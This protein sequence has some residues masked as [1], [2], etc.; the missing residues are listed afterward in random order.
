MNKGVRESILGYEN[1]MFDDMK[2]RN[3][4][5]G[6]NADGEAVEEKAREG[7]IVKR[8]NFNLIQKACKVLQLGLDMIKFAL[9]KD[10]SG[11]SPGDTSHRGKPGR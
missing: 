8:P 9:Q 1:S 6:V 10:F 3:S 5:I 11:S 7:P 4:I 2:T